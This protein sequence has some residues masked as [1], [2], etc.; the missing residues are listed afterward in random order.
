M[1]THVKSIA[2]PFLYSINDVAAVGKE[3][4]YYSN[5]HYF[6]AGHLRKMEDILQ[7]PWGNVGVYEE[8]A[9]RVLDTSIV[10]PNGVTLS[11]D[12]R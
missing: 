11:P 10:Y 8:N 2:N 12:G 6:E 7:L 3:S 1:A 5:D 9:T 4:F